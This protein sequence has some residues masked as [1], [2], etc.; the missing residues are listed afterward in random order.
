VLTAACCSVLQCAA[1]CCSVL[2]C[3]AVCCSVLQWG[4]PILYLHIWRTC[5]RYQVIYQQES[6][7]RGY[8]AGDGGN[9][10]ELQRFHC[11]ASRSLPPLLPPPELL[12]AQI[13]L[14]GREDGGGGGGGGGGGRA[15]S[16]REG[17][18]R[19]RERRER[20]DREKRE[21]DEIERQ[22]RYSG[23]ECQCGR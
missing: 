5:R 23:N 20:G 10:W 6:K 1:V 3:V 16:K 13:Q 21:R 17:D 22:E 8:G 11:L 4:N 7:T 18:R 12:G 14:R 19:E 2:Q 15:E 9:L